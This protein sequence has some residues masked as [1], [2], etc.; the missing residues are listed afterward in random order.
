MAYRVT[1]SKD[2]EQ[3]T[4]LHIPSGTHLRVTGHSEKRLSEVDTR[5]LVYHGDVEVW[6]R[7]ASQV[8]PTEGNVMNDIMALAPIVIEMRDVDVEVEIIDPASK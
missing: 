5:T 3:L 4:T 2:G 1:V 7:A 6:L 8:H